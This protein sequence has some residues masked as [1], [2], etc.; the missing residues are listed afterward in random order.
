MLSLILQPA[1]LELETYQN[2]YKVMLVWYI[3][4]DVDVD[5]EVF[6]TCI[7][8]YL[9][10]WVELSWVSMCID[11]I[12]DCRCSVLDVRSIWNEA[13]LLNHILIHHLAIG[14]TGIYSRPTLVQVLT[15]G[16]NTAVQAGRGFNHHGCHVLLCTCSLCSVV[17]PKI[18][19]SVKSSWGDC[20]SPPGLK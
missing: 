13:C 5:L 20:S 6:C 17:K 3:R 15:E 14:H 16:K 7:R 1:W 19:F 10:S 18:Q 2:V 8:N 12:L 11:S 4:W 9:L